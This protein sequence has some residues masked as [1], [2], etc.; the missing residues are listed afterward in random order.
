MITFEQFEE[1]TLETA[2]T[3]PEEFFR[4]L[5]GGVM[6][7]EHSRLHPAA[8]DHDL[9]VMGEYHRD[10]YLGRFV[11]L[12]Y[13]SFA[14]CFRTCPD[15]VW[16]QEIRRV[17]LHEFR[18]HLESLA[19]ERDLEIEDAVAVSQYKYR[20]QEE[21]YLTEKASGYR[22]DEASL[23]KRTNVCDTGTTAIEEEIL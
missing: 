4:E 18:H 15:V 11:V 1:I 13:G 6:V 10:R 12:Y 9:F 22:I 5:S 16:R 14:A 8:V 17:L 19:G 23:N 3:F 2:D 7:Q 20:K 21:K